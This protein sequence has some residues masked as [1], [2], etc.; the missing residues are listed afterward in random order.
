M[1][2][3]LTP[4]D[5]ASISEGLKTRYGAKLERLFQLELERLKSMLISSPPERIQ[6]LQGRAQQLD[7]IIKLFDTIKSK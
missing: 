7:D 4:D 2:T 3:K 6:L 5:E 1:L